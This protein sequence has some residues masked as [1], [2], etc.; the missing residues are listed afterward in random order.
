MVVLSEVVGEIGNLVYAGAACFLPDL[1]R[2]VLGE[3]KLTHI[4][5]ICLINVYEERYSN[6]KC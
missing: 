4:L 1:V 2:G 3:Y 5:D 6:F